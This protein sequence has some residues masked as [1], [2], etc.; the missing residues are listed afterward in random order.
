MATARKLGRLEFSEA[1]FLSSSS[2]DDDSDDEIL[3]SLATRP[4]D[5]TPKVRDFVGEVVK[6]Y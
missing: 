1:V 6:V 2:D 3:L 5:E 4:S